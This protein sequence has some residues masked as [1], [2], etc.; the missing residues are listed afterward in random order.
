MF[1]DVYLCLTSKTLETAYCRVFKSFELADAYFSL[2]RFSPDVSS[3]MIDV[4]EFMP[5][6]LQEYYIQRQCMKF[7]EFKDKSK[8]LFDTHNWNSSLYSKNN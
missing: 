2:T 6:T 3:T 5:R 1:T 4:C 7:A 8:W